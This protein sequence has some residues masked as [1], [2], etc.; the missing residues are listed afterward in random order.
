MQYRTY[1]EAIE[2]IDWKLLKQQKK[3]LEKLL[4]TLPLSVKS[5]NI[6]DESLSELWGL[7]ELIEILQDVHENEPNNIVHFEK[8]IK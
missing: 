7:I 2:N 6:P 8:M 3:T 4:P 5:S 1:Q